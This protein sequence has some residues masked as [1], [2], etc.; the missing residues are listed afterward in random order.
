MKRQKRMQP[1]PLG[2][3]ARRAASPHGPHLIYIRARARLP[4]LL[5]SFL[6]FCP[7]MVFHGREVFRGER[8]KEKQR[9]PRRQI[10]GSLR[11]HASIRRAR[12]LCGA[13]RRMGPGFISQGA[14]WFPCLWPRYKCRSAPQSSRRGHDTAERRRTNTHALRF[15]RGRW[16]CGWPP[17]S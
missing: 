1:R 10:R 17:A 12:S 9:L 3:P 11:S 5:R 13:A 7:H 15:L 2:P 6:S 16:L 14:S 8:R 4:A